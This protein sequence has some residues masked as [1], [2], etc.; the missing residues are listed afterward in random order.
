MTRRRSQRDLVDKISNFLARN[1]GLPI[2]LG[3]GLVFISLMLGL[4][5]A[6]EEAGGF[7]GWL[8]RSD[9]AL[10]LGVI[11]GLLGVLLGDAL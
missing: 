7:W 6:L 4:F 8:A 9:L 10:H 1:K 2:F 5:P 3:V 11:V